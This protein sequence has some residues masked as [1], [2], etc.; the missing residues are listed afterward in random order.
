MD[1]RW[2]PHEHVPTHHR[3]PWV[4]KNVFCLLLQI[5]DAS[6]YATWN[7]YVKASLTH[8]VFFALCFT[9]RV[10]ERAIFRL[11]VLNGLYCQTRRYLIRTMDKENANP[12]RNTSNINNLKNGK[13]HTRLFLLLYRMNTSCLALLLFSQKILRDLLQ[14][15]FFLY[16]G[17]CLYFVFFLNIQKQIIQDII[18]ISWEC[19]HV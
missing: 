16:T 9:E 1:F 13:T 18:I 2:F 7:N 8:K 11:G 3:T 14:Y 5:W 12:Y 15:V 10:R 19:N 4:K 17:C 6:Q